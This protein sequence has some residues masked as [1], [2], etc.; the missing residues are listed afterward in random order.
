MRRRREEGESEGRR[1]GKGG[2]GSIT[3]NGSVR[4][5]VYVRVLGCLFLCVSVRER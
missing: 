2:G 4:L 1:E 3:K 5:C